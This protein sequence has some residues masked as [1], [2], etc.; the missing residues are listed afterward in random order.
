VVVAVVV[1]VSSTVT[2]GVKLSVENTVTVLMRV[3]KVLPA[4]SYRVANTASVTYLVAGVT[5]VT[6]N[7]EQSAAPARVE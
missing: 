5:V 6:R 7:P 1:S 2:L 3:R 4:Y